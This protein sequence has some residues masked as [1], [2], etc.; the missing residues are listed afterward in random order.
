MVKSKLVIKG[1]SAGVLPNGYA[2]AG[3]VVL[4]GK[5]AALYRTE[6]ETWLLSFS[7]HCRRGIKCLNL[8]L[9]LCQKKQISV[10]L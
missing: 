1:V 9:P 8:T 2:N 5:K 6:N 10:F 4:G 3:W 7:I